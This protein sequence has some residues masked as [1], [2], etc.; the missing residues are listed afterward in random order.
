MIFSA[1]LSKYGNDNSV[2]IAQEHH[3]H[4]NNKRY[5]NIL[6]NKYY[7]IDYLFALT[8]KL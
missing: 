4:N 3:Y 8:K 5:I 7:N 6:K 2:K 1:L